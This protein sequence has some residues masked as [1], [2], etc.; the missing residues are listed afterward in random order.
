MPSG[1]PRGRRAAPAPAP[2]AL[3]PRAGRPLDRGRR[4]R[5]SG[6]AAA[7]ARA[8]RLPHGRASGLDAFAGL[9]PVVPGAHDRAAGRAAAAPAASGSPG[10]GRSA[11]RTSSRCCGRTRSTCWSPRRAAARRPTP[12]WPRR[13]SSGCRWSWSADR[14]RRPARW[15]TRSKRRWPGWSGLPNIRPPG[16][17]H[18]GDRGHTAGCRGNPRSPARA[19]PGSARCG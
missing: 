18:G 13:G 17:A 8:A 3:E 10:A 12:S 9:E 2:A 16:A 15:S 14:R 5:R 1:L 7:G 19:R 4:P 11:S 6:A